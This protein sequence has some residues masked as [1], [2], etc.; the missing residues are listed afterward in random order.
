MN[1]LGIKHSCGGDARVLGW[2]D[3]KKFRRCKCY[4]C[5]DEFKVPIDPPKGK[6]GIKAGP[7]TIGAG[8]RWGSTRLG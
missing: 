1:L 5:G 3:N 6:T 4:S 8:F 2:T 7:I